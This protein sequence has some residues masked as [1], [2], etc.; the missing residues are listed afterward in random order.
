MGVAFGFA[1]GAFKFFGFG[2]VVVDLWEVVPVSVGGGGVRG[3][4]GEEDL[5]AL[6]IGVAV[7]VLVLVV[8][9]V[10]VLALVVLVIRVVVPVVTVLVIVLVIV[11][12]ELRLE[13]PDR[14]AAP[15]AGNLGLDEGVEVGLGWI[16]GCKRVGHVPDDGVVL[17]VL[18]MDAAEEGEG[19]ATS[20]G[21]L[22]MASEDHD[23][24]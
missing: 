10:V 18:G 7:L 20:A 5:G 11:V 16:G 14:F 22:M 15:H 23:G 13:G 8:I 21:H 24:R 6:V 4:G 3:G 1:G 9:C 2:E 12:I 19:D 17:G